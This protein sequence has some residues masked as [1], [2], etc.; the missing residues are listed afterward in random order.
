MNPHFR[1][2]FET[3]R[4]LAPSLPWHW[5]IWGAAGA[6]LAVL[7]VWSLGWV[8]ARLR[9]QGKSP[10]R[11]LGTTLLAAISWPVTVAIIAVL[12][13]PAGRMPTVVRRS[14]RFWVV[15][16]GVVGTTIVVCALIDRELTTLVLFLVA[17]TPVFLAFAPLWLSTLALRLVLAY[18]DSVPGITA[19]GVIVLGMLAFTVWRERR[20]RPDQTT[21]ASL[22]HPG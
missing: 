17:L 6:V 18:S 9:V 12:Y 14:R 13:P 21:T 3:L 5:A 4:P 16:A 15:L 1:D 22:Q 11:A 2:P 20:T 10:G 7:F 8:Y 19:W